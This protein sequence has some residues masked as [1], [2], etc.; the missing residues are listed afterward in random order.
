MFNDH[1]IDKN[2]GKYD[3]NGEDDEIGESDA[4]I[5]AVNNNKNNSDNNNNDNSNHNYGM[6]VLLRKT[7]E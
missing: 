2:N 1:K 5:V 7:I 3:E 4:P 6:I